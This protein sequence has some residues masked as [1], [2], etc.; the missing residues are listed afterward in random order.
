[1]TLSVKHIPRNSK[2]VLNGN[3]L[4]VVP[5]RLDG[6]LVI[7]GNECEVCLEGLQGLAQGS[8][9]INKTENTKNFEKGFEK[10][11][12]DR[13]EI[14]NEKRQVIQ[15][16]ANLVALAEQRLKQ[17][18]R[19]L[20]KAKQVEEQ[21]MQVECQ[22]LKEQVRQLQEKM[23]VERQNQMEQVK[24]LQK[25]NQVQE[26]RLQMECQKHQDEFKQLEQRMQVESQNM[27]EQVKQLQETKLVDEKTMQVEFQKHQDEIKQHEDARQLVELRM[28]GETHIHLYYEKKLK[29]LDQKLQEERQNHKIQLEQLQ[30]DPKIQLAKQID[31]A[32]KLYNR[33]LEQERQNHKIQ[34]TQVQDDA[35]YQVAKQVDAACQS[36]NRKLQQERREFEV[37]R[38]RFYY[39][40]LLQAEDE[41]QRK[42]REL[43]EIHEIAAANMQIEEDNKEQRWMEDQRR[44]YLEEETARHRI[45]DQEI[46]NLISSIGGIINSEKNIRIPVQKREYSDI[47]EQVQCGITLDPITCN[48]LCGVTNCNHWFDR[49]KI[50]E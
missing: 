11:L 26:Q 19:E 4:V 33:K 30:D 31:E 1:M 16:T 24:Q 49:D 44:E 6:I 42:Q 28:Q 46:D 9:I 13:A 34:I 5:S 23:L 38:E 12:D 37:E 21:R 45:L 27:H 17:Q 41:S 32:K 15:N 10:G 40:H 8:V 39:N 47:P 22:Y 43:Q 50:I 20:Q 18:V 35:K 3:G 48:T 25:A 36:I 14:R 2:L 7:N 29:K